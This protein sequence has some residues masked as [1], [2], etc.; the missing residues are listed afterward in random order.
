MPNSLE[1]QFIADT[2]KALLHTG[3][4]SLSSGSPDAKIY[5]GDGFESSLSVSTISNGIKVSGDATIYGN[6][7]S[8]KSGNFSGSLSSG[9]HT[10]T[11]DS[12]IS[13][14]VDVAGGIN[15]GGSLNSGSHTVTGNSNISGTLASASHTVTGNSNISGTARVGGTTTI[16]GSL[17][18]G[19][20]TVTGN[21]NIS[22][23]AR[24]GGTTTIIGS[25]SSGSHTVTGNSNIS[26]TARV[27][28][29]T[30]IIGSLSSGS[31]TVT[32]N[33]RITNRIDTNTIYADTYLNLPSTDTRADIVNHIY[34]VGSIFLSFTNVNPS[35][36]FTGTS[37]VQVSQGR[38][39]V[40]VGTGNDGIQNKIFTAGNNTGEYTHQLTIAEMPSHTH[41]TYAQPSNDGDDGGGSDWNPYSFLTESSA[42]GGDQYHNNTPPGFGL[43]VWQRTV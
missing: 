38:F 15:I 40:G 30:T 12:N 20:H 41:E 4:I 10:V 39:V 42:T 8:S 28:G 11:G 33:S 31:H 36:R 9:S 14:S 32:G 25:L 29:T 23:T 2:F 13:G 16:I 21:S 19:S 43:Y 5:S 24:V 18:S 34:P 37:W 35:V 22:G 3:N 6:V 17:S 7:I 27:G 1:N 26:G